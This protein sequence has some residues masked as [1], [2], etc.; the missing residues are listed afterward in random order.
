MAWLASQS[1]HHFG[2]IVLLKKSD[3]SD[4]SRSRI[5]AGTSVRECDAAQGKDGDLLPASFA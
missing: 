2:D 1:P 4:A 3:R 5:N